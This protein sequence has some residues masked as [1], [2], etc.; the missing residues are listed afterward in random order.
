MQSR[1]T[2]Y[3]NVVDCQPEERI[4]FDKFEKKKGYE[5]NVDETKKLT[6]TENV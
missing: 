6:P 3:L 5:R 2:K 4:D 1:A